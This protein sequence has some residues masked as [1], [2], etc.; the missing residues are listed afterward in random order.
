MEKQVVRVGFEVFG[1]VQGVFFRQCTLQEAQRL[2]LKGYVRN[3][4]RGTVQG[5]VEG[6]KLVVEQMKDWLSRVGSPESRIDRVDFSSLS[7]ED[8]ALFQGFS[9]RH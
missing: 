8:Q 3:T 1:H 4:D 5:A 2:G 6:P 7:L 9:V